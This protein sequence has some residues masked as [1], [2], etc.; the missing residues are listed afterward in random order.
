VELDVS[1]GAGAL[2]LWRLLRKGQNMG[3]GA[4]KGAG[5]GEDG[6]GNW[7]RPPI[8]YYR[9][10]ISGCFFSFGVGKERKPWKGGGSKDCARHQSQIK[11]SCRRSVENADPKRRWVGERTILNFLPA[12]PNKG[13][14]VEGEARSRGTAVLVLSLNT[15]RE[16]RNMDRAAGGDSQ[17]KQMKPFPLSQRSILV[18]ESGEGSA[19]VA[20]WRRQQGQ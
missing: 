4:Q 19:T 6:A 3:I 9:E 12:K 10:E 13:R 17:R 7:A 1:V 16:A 5:S 2:L 14:G 20:T 11:I 15:Q 18:K 8:C